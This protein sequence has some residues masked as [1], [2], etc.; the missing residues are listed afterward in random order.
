MSYGTILNKITCSSGCSKYMKK[1][2]GL[3]NDFNDFSEHQRSYFRESLQAS[4]IFQTRS[5]GRHLDIVNADDN[6]Y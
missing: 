5:F 6:N 2:L 3:F 4:G 1:A